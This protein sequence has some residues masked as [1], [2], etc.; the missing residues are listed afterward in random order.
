MVKRCKL[1]KN[2]LTKMKLQ[3]QQTADINSQAVLSNSMDVIVRWLKHS[4]LLKSITF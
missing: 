1:S 3:E 4:V 2:E